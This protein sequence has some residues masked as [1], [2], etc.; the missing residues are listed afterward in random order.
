MNFQSEGK[1]NSDQIGKEADYDYNYPAGMNLKPGSEI[2]NNIRDRL[3]KMAQD[4]YSAMECR[5]GA[6][7]EMDRTLT[8][9]ID[10]D[11]EEKEIKSQD[12]RRPVT[13]VVPITYATMET[14][15]TY[16]VAAFLED[17]IFRYEGTGPE[18]TI[19]AILLERNIELQV[20]RMKTALNLHTMWRDALA[21]GFGVVAADWEKVKGF[22]TV[23]KNTGFVS[24]VFNRFIPGR[25][26]QN[27]EMKT[28]YEGNILYNIDP[29]NYLPDPNTSLENIQRSEYQGW[30]DRTNRITLLSDEND[31]DSILFNVRYL[32]HSGDNRSKNFR[33]ATETGRWDKTGWTDDTPRE[34]GN[35]VD[36]LHMYVNLVPSEWGLGDGDYP[37]KWYFALAGDAVLIAAQP[38]GLDHNR[39]PLA[40]DCPNYDGHSIVP[41]GVLEVMHGLQGTAD[42][43]YRTHV[44]NV[45]KAIND[46]LI[47]DPYL[48][49]Y[50]DLKTPEPGKLVRMRRAAWGRGVKEAV[51]QLAITDITAQNIPDISFIKQLSEE[52]TG[53]V[54]QLK[55]IRRRTSERVSATEAQ[56]V[57]SSALSRLEKYAR[58]SSIQSHFDLAYLFAAHTKQLMS[59][60]VYVNMI[61]R[62]SEELFAEYGTDQTRVKVSPK[63]IDIDVD[64]MPHDGSIPGS[65]DGQA[66]AKVFE[67]L[68]SHPV[69]SQ[70]FDIVRVF[71]HL[72]RQLG[73]RNVNDFVRRDVNTRVL[74]E[75]TVQEEERKGNLVPI[76]G[77]Q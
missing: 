30:M 15:L 5:V 42:W 43:L 56:Q 13:I 11:D 45:R 77:L 52:V 64:V 70:N 36:V 48:V 2:H 74:P 29:Y 12:P 28:L 72:T 14:L 19:G 23:E 53:A 22:K 37:E 54:D 57:H 66:W 24:E 35:I 39:F 6:W 63:D 40:V 25:T 60:E 67:I 46:M 59:E 21:Y 8:A 41:I 20:R 32:V 7:Q 51:Q 31:V 26:V 44:A 61:G 38:T 9:Y 71:K 58:L 33:T 68:A 47:V 34:T 62:L 49:N 76:G 27:R 55:G 1:K 18:D 10:L 17:P 65:S 3:L 69:I 73:A 50:N 75:E 16:Q 4:S